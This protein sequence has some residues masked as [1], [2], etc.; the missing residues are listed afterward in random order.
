MARAG[1]EFGS[2]H[3]RLDVRGV[4]TFQGIVALSSATYDDF[5]EQ[6]HQTYMHTYRSIQMHTMFKTI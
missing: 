1:G 3:S 4:L 2:P 5:K 6:I